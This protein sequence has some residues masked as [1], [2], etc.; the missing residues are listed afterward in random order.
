MRKVHIVI[1]MLI[2]IMFNFIFNSFAYAVTEPSTD[3]STSDSNQD[4]NTDNSSNTN[5][6]TSSSSGSSSSSSYQSLSKDGYVDIETS[7]GTISKKIGISDSTL[8]SGAGIIASMVV[9]WGAALS[10]F[11]LTNFIM[12]GRIVAC[13]K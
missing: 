7:S 11:L 12:Q 5:T 6:D 2:V 13:R 1:L 9:P 10:E 4:T 3:T 8:G